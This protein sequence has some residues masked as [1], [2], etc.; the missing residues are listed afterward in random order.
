VVPS[1][2]SNAPSDVTVSAIGVPI[3]VR[4]H[5]SRAGRLA[6]HVRDAWRDCL[7][8]GAG[9]LVVD[10]LLD[11]EPA[12]VDDALRRGM[13]ADRSLDVVLDRLSPRVTGDAITRHAG[14]L[15]MLHACG[16]ADPASGA[17]VALVA[18]SGMGKTT[19]SRALGLKWRYL[20]DETVAIGPDLTVVPYAKPLSILANPADVTKQQVAAS[21]LGLLLDSP[22]PRLVGV[23]VLDRD[24][25]GP[26]CEVSE[27][28]TVMALA[29]L[30]PQTSFLGRFE[31]P[32]HHLAGVLKRV[33]G[34]R[35]VRYRE[36]ATLHEVMADLVGGRS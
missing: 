32:L 9:S 17:A 18:R 23:A 28:P 36:A 2:S 26:E 12:A 11:D 16:L 25:A 8:D 19:V 20:S 13:V 5:G 6:A 15:T 34:L 1:G 30:A 7:V 22:P 14:E 27:V 21:S 3:T 35:R 29:Q 24:P 33:G 4:C 10:A 31:R